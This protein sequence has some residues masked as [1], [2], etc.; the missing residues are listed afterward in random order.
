MG[1]LGASVPTTDGLIVGCN[2]Y[3]C[4]VQEDACQEHRA[5]TALGNIRE[6]RQMSFTSGCGSSA[7]VQSTRYC[8]KMLKI[9]ALPTPLA[10]RALETRSLESSLRDSLIYG[11]CR[12]SLRSF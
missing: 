7:P 9:R 10:T 5:L 4:Q 2:S 6:M 11:L 12:E 8:F 1:V 3:L